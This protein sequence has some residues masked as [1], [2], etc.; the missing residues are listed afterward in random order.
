[1][2]HPTPE[3]SGT[4]TWNPPAQGRGRRGRRSSATMMALIVGFLLGAGGVDV[5][6]YAATGDSL[7]LGRIN[8]AD[9]TTTLT[10]SGTTPALRLRT[11]DA[12][13]LAVSSQAMVP[14]LNSDKVDG[15]N[16]KSLGVGVREYGLPD[17]PEFSTSYSHDVPDLKFGESYLLTYAITVTFA[18]DATPSPVRC[19]IG[20][21][22]PRPHSTA[23]AWGSPVPA[24]GDE[25]SGYAFIG[26]SGVVNINEDAPRAHLHCTSDA[27]FAVLSDDS[28]GPYVL[29]T[30]LTRH[31]GGTFGEPTR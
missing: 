28:Y 29:I 12:P 13:P 24:V 30:Y 21:S 18:D 4:S 5:S 15:R 16:A 31:V 3:P 22:G 11:G 10:T 26:A 7:V 19:A 25:L 8:H 23:W 27:E 20:G 6:T 2:D 14:R 9:R 17:S 1:M